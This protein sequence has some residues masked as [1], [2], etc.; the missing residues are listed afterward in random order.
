LTVVKAR[1]VTRLEGPGFIPGP[2]KRDAVVAEFKIV[3]ADPRHGV[4]VQVDPELLTD[5]A[6]S[7]GSLARSVRGESAI[8]TLYEIGAFI[9]SD[10]LPPLTASLGLSSRFAPGRLIDAKELSPSE[11]EVFGGSS[12]DLRVQGP[13]PPR[14]SGH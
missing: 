13:A 4:Q 6:F 2:F 8:V 3:R 11:R 10:V 7:K 14:P 9:A 12:E 1:N 5:I